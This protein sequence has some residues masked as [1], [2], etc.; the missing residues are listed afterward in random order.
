M[1][2]KT[3][4]DY[5]FLFEA[6]SDRCR[7]ESCTGSGLSDPE[8]WI[9]F[10]WCNEHQLSIFASSSITMTAILS[11]VSSDSKL[12][13]VLSRGFLK[14]VITSDHFSDADVEAV[15]AFHHSVTPYTASQN[16]RTGH[17][18]VIRAKEDPSDAYRQH[19]RLIS[20]RISRAGRHTA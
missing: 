19:R 11:A 3:I 20:S 10:Y 8:T 2:K 12:F 1:T 15:K 6:E 5:I 4:K 9:Y 14:F 13:S 18:T 7:A 17:V 16:Q